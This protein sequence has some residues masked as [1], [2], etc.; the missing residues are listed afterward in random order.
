MTVKDLYSK[1]Y[2]VLDPKLRHDSDTILTEEGADATCREVR[3]KKSGMVKIFKFDQKP[4]NASELL[5]FFLN[6]SDGHKQMC[7]YVLFYPYK[8][9]LVVYICNLKSKK[10]DNSARQIKNGFVF[11]KY[12]IEMASL[13]LDQH[14]IPTFV[15]FKAIHLLNPKTKY[16]ITTNPRDMEFK[17]YPN[18]LK[19]LLLSGNQDCNL[20]WLAE[21]D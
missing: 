13:C 3:L 16:K 5:P 10:L 20:D 4:S 12:V 7:D 6:T 18:N 15:E 8:E 21:M 19:Y 17:T 14:H 9:K 11:S 2:D 1:I